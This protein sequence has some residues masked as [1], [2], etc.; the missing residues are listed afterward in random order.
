AD[1]V[2]AGLRDTVL[3]NAGA[4][5]WIAG[6]E[7]SLQEGVSRAE[8]TLGSGRVAQWLDNVRSFYQSIDK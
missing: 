5:L 3:L 1:S 2:P 7:S 6:G 4:A 8:D